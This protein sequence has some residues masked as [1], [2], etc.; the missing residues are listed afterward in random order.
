MDVCVFL[1]VSL[2]GL[3]R[4]FAV[5][6]SNRCYLARRLG[7]T[8]SVGTVRE[9]KTR[10]T[11]GAKCK[12]DVACVPVLLLVARECVCIS[13]DARLHGQKKLT[14]TETLASSS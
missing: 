12:D 5:T 14:L 4:T 8:V 13:L 7:R 11:H 10:N 1:R 6:K 3:S 2:C 9:R